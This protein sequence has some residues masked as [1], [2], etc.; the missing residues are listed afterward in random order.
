MKIEKEIF[1]IGEV[2]FDCYPDYKM[3]GGAP[4]NFIYHTKQLTGK[5]VFI[6]RIGMDHNGRELLELIQSSELDACFIQRD[7]EHKTGIVNITLDKNKIPEFI[8][9]EN[10]AYDFIEL[11]GVAAGLIQNN[12][13]MIYF[14]TLAQRQTASRGSIHK[15]FDLNIPL[16]CDVNLRQH[17]YSKEILETSLL[18][19]TIVKLNEEELKIVNELFVRSVFDLSGT[20]REVMRRF[21]IELLCITLGSEGAVLFKDYEVNRYQHETENIKDTVG[22]GDAYS[23]ILCLG[24]LMKWSLDRINRTASEF[25]A[26][27]CGIAGAVPNDNNFYKKYMEVI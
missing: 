20:S 22:A 12:G 23:A 2:L 3:P 27:I 7:N 19:S 13:S 5:G 26:D 24:Y 25:A 8:I 11:T 6:S 16:F 9:E 18:N 10:T 21:N 1:A 4:F 14:G 17:Y 15:L